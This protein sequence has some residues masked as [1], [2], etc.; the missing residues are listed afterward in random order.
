MTPSFATDRWLAAVVA[1][2]VPAVSRLLAEGVRCGAANVR[3]QQSLHLA[4]LHDHEDL[5]AVLVG[6]YLAQGEPLIFRTQQ[7]YSPLGYAVLERRTRLARLLLNAGVDPAEPVATLYGAAANAWLQAAWVGA[8]PILKV[9]PVALAETALPD[10]RTALHLATEQG[11]EAALNWLLQRSPETGPRTTAGEAP[12]HFAKTV[13]T[14]EA[15]FRTVGAAPMEEPD[16]RGRTLIHR[17]AMDKT[18]PADAAVW[19]VRHLP[20]AVDRA[21]TTGRTPLASALVAGHG[22][23]VDVLAAAAASWHRPDAKGQTPWL[24]LQASGFPYNEEQRRQWAGLAQAQRLASSLP[25]AEAS[26]IRRL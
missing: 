6:A 15:W 16:D 25:R 20:Q 14:L 19:A 4:I 17:L 22:A 1:G 12:W 10:G 13:E 18:A 11:H 3:G 8:L 23:A 21:D 26:A 5:A 2:D 9:L 7:G 24:I